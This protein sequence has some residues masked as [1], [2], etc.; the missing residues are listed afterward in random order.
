MPEQSWAKQYPTTLEAN[1]AYTAREIIEETDGF[2]VCGFRSVQVGT[3]PS[4]TNIFVLRINEAGDVVWLNNYDIANPEEGYESDEEANSI[5]KNSEG[6]YYIAGVQTL[7]PIPN[8]NPPPETFPSSQAIVLEVMADGTLSKTFIINSDADLVEAKKISKTVNDTYLVT[9]SALDYSTSNSLAQVL[10]A[11]F[12]G[13][14][15]NSLEATN[16]FLKDNGQNKTGTGYCATLLTDKPTDY[17][18]VVA[19][20]TIVNKFDMFI[21]NTNETGSVGWQHILG[22]EENDQ[23]SSLSLYD[24]GIYLSGYSQVPVSSFHAYR[25]YLAKMDLYGTIGWEKT[26]GSAGQLYTRTAMKIDDGNIMM[27]GHIQGN[28]RNYHPF[29]LKVGSEAGDSLWYEQLSTNCALNA[30]ICTSDFQYLLAGK[31]I[32]NEVPQKKILLIKFGEDSGTGIKDTQEASED[33]MLAPCYPNPVDSEGRID[34]RIPRPGHVS[35]NVFNLSG[36]LVQ[37]LVNAELDQ[38]DHSVLWNAQKLPPGTYFLN[39]ES[40]GMVRRQKVVVI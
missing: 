10:L 16:F 19:G 15:E 21:M 9:G 27:I 5:V 14:E 22:G 2:V 12:T 24:D 32:E 4:T 31:Y 26:Y 37:T 38:G 18:Y 3:N 13:S 40:N 23:V 30:A 1:A 25:A 36:Q 6:N 8:P 35:L 7:P 20:N 39:L 34:F 28:D 29:F 33:F 17:K 11:E